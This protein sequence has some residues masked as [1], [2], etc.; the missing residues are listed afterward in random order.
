LRKFRNR[1]DTS[2]LEDLGDAIQGEKSLAQHGIG[3]EVLAHVLRLS[4]QQ[5]RFGLLRTAATIDGPH[6]IVYTDIEE[7]TL[8]IPHSLGDAMSYVR[9]Y[10]LPVRLRTGPLKSL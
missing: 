6:L 10:A 9:D 7:T 3:I 8:K 5:Q 1:S 2:L 4:S